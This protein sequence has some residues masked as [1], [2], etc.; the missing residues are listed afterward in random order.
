[1][2]GREITVNNSQ[3]NNSDREVVKTHDMTEKSINTKGK[4]EYG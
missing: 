3:N 4:L 1:M 2:S